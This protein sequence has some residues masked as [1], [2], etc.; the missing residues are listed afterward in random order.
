MRPT[1]S[2]SWLIRSAISTSPSPTCGRPEGAR[3]PAV[4]F[5]DF[6]EMCRQK[7]LL[8]EAEKA[9][10]RAV[11]LDPNAPGGSNDLGIALQE[12]LKLDESPALSRT[13]ARPRS[14]Q[15]A[16]AQRP[17][18]YPEAPRRRGGSGEALERG[19][20][21]SACTTPRPTAISR[22]W[23]WTRANTTAPTPW[24][25]GR[26]NSARVLPTPMSISPRFKP[27]GMTTPTRC[28]S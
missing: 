9:G 19:P 3:T 25:V 7:G 14:E 2:A 15:P 8:V 28:R 4:Y 21:A 17:R 5:S 18:Q 26:S 24:R 12:A 20:C 6:A 13:R 11:A 16:D 23:L 22:T 1:S 27:R 10:R